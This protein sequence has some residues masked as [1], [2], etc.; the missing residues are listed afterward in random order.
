MSVKEMAHN[1][2]DNLTEEQVRGFIMMFGSVSQMDSSWDEE[3]P[4]EHLLKA[5]Q[6]TED[7]LSG[8]IE[9]KCYNSVEELFEDL[10]S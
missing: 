10:N 8:K 7:I 6:E 4:N 2:I 5:M 9:A 3:I 1:I